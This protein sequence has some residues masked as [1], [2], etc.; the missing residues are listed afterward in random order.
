MQLSTSYHAEA[1]SKPSQTSRMEFFAKITNDLQTLIVF[2]KNFILNAWKG[3]EYGSVISGNSYL[4]C[5]KEQSLF[6][7]AQMFRILRKGV[8][9]CF[10]WNFGQ[11]SKYHWEIPSCSEEMNSL[12]TEFVSVDRISFSSL[13]NKSN[14][15]LWRN[16]SCRI[17]QYLLQNISM[18]SFFYNANPETL[19]N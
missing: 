5:S 12:R 6:V 7:N 18:K 11:S 16:D 3:S 8:W 19:K 9:K 17:N 10:L 13:I 14:I 4:A 1:Y 2:A 15:I